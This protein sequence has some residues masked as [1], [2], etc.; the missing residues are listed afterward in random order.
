VGDLEANGLLDQAT[1]IH[2]GVFKDIE[3]GEVFTFRPHQIA[4]EMVAFLKSVD[5]LIMHNGIQYDFP[6]M[7]K[8]LGYS[9]QGKKVDTLIMSRLHRPNRTRPP[10]MV[11]KGGPHSIAA[12]GYR[13]GRGKP[14][15]D[16]WENFSEEMLHR[17][18]E[19]VEILH[20]VYDYL[21]EER[22]RLG[23]SWRDAYLM[24][25]NLF[26]ILRKQEEYGWLVDQQQLDKNLYFLQMWMD[27][28][29]KVLAD[30]LPYRSE[31]NEEKDKNTGQRKYIKEAFL[32]KGGY[33]KKVAEY[34]EGSSHK[35]GGPFSRVSFRQLSL[36]KDAE[37]KDYLLS[38]G[39]EPLEW[40]RSKKTGEITSPKLSHSDPFEG[41]Q[42]SMGKLI[43]KRVQCKSRKS[44]CNGWKER[45]R[46]DGRLPSKVTGL[47][48]T[49][50][51]THSEIV[52]VPGGD[53]FFG[54]WMRKIFTCP[55]GRTLIGCDAKGCQDRML[56]ERAKSATLTDMLLNGSKGKGTDGHSVAMKA[57]NVAL[58]E[59]G[60][61]LIKRGK[62]KNYN[63]A[64]KFGARDPKI[65]NMAGGS[66]ALG[67]RIREEYGKTPFKGQLEVVEALTKE[68]KSNAQVTYQ[69]GKPR[70][71]NGWIRGLDGRPIQI[72]AE[73][74]ILVYM[75]QSDEAIMMT[76]AYVM[77]YKRLLAKGLKWGEDWAY[78]CWYHDEYT[79]ECREELVDIIEPMAEQAIADA[80][81]L[82]GLTYCPQVGEAEHGSNWW[83]I[84]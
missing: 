71:K 31:C 13:V 45:I 20:L 10:H 39:W 55:P 63:F 33:I 75:L 70:Y 78:V 15:H 22:T 60:K 35:V 5:V 12:W 38:L 74:T 40:N 83:D 24:T 29:D 41:V 73:H 1:T 32:K 16:D 51:A 4:N 43:A 46:D 67:A 21:T 6:L 82:F 77:L 17:C 34:Y 66:P 57:V 50:R 68:W 76:A 58:K 47:A 49:G 37:I 79:I 23:G 69:Y 3:T 42:G 36:D 25:F 48:E 44:I 28:I 11:G 27:R 65:G 61:P 26:D 8:L 14:D 53:S 59:A 18:T 80:G 9:Y 30:R 62:A 84:H 54:K 2:C 56:A 52:N 64:M 72:S 19:D 81:K 7:E